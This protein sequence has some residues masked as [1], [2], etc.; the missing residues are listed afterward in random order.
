[1]GRCRRT[2]RRPRRAAIHA[3]RSEHS[4][5]EFRR[6]AGSSTPQSGHFFRFTTAAIHPDSHEPRGIFRSAGLV[7]DTRV[8]IAV[9]DRERFEDVLAWFNRH[10]PFPRRVTPEMI[11][12][13]RP[14]ARE[15]ASRI[16]ELV[17]LLREH[18]VLVQTMRTARPGRIVYSDG[19]QVG[20]VPYRA[21]QRTIRLFA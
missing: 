7:L 15:C 16:W 11:F 1:M 13:F 3:A 2:I 10:L 12:W 9:A 4:A 17:H 14:E 5:P 8:D 21:V 19:M 6:W 20:A 18:G